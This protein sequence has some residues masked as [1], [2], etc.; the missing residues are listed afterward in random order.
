M[1]SLDG[2]SGSSNGLTITSK[3]CAEERLLIRMR[4]G[5]A[6]RKRNRLRGYLLSVPVL[7]VLLNSDVDTTYGN[8]MRLSAE[9]AHTA[10]VIPQQ[11]RPAVLS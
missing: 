9:N 4:L 11:T 2:N 1:I 3:S 6:S 5:R 8:S 7:A 10:R